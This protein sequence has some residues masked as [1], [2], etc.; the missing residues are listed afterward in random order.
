MFSLCVP[1]SGN[2][3][4]Y[5]FCMKGGGGRSIAGMNAKVVIAIGRY[6]RISHKI[7]FKEHVQQNSI[8]HRECD[9]CVSSHRNVWYV[10]LTDTIGV[11]MWDIFNKNWLETKNKLNEDFRLYSSMHDMNKDENRWSYCNY[12]KNVGFPRDCGPH[13]RVNWNWY[14]E[15]NGAAHMKDTRFTVYWMDTKPKIDGYAQWKP[16]DF[17]WIGQPRCFSPRSGRFT[18]KP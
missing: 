6:G 16:K 4:D 9:R 7:L 3:R 11:D 8:V 5:A 12:A 1:S 18:E 10:R 17:A 13:G 14:F 15:G 2:H